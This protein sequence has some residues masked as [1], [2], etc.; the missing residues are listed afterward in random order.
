MEKCNGHDHFFF[1][2][3]VS[4][5]KTLNFVPKE[6]VMKKFLIGILSL[7]VLAGCEN[8]P[9]MV[10]QRKAEIRRN[11]S[12]ELAQARKDLVVVDSIA[13]FRA[14]E[15]EELKQ[16]FVFEKQEKYQTLGY[17]VLPAYKGSK[18]R[19][20]FFPEVE[21]GGKLLLVSIDK[22]RQYS[23]QEIDLAADDYTTQLPAGLSS[24]ML[25]D[26]AKCHVLAKAIWDLADAQRQRGK[27]EQEVGFYEEKRKKY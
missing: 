16:Q 14:L 13:T 24:A 5:V 1:K 20:S 25:Q 26:V 2:K 17:Y 18:E 10:E 4:S 15:L 3:V 8:R 7:F 23:F 22:K 21:E 19:F 12:L 9:S 11:D 6:C 27:L